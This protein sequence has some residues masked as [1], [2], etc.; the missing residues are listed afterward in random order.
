MSGLFR[1]F[2]A[3][4]NQ[5]V[6]GFDSADDIGPKRQQQCQ[7]SAVGGVADAKPDD[8]WSRAAGEQPLG[9]VLILGD[10]CGVIGQR[11]IPDVGVFGFPQAEFPDGLH[12]V[13]D[14]AQCAGQSR[15]KL[16]IDN[17]LHAGCR[18]L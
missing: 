7:Q 2:L 12:V 14:F 13:P 3:D 5:V 9:K 18:T 16:G 10:D 4:F 6:A 15:R 1:A 8:H 17:E 11:V